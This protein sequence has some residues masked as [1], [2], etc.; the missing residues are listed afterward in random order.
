[1]IKDIPKNKQ[2]I[3]FDGVC[4]LCN[5]SV[6]YVIKR[7]KK[8]IFLFAPLQSKTGIELINK[9]NIDTTK[10]DSILLYNPKSNSLKQKSS[11]AIHIAKYLGFPSNLLTVFFIIP[12]FIRNWVYDYV[13][14][15][16]YKWY[17]KKDAC[18]IPTPEL[19]SKFIT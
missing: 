7:D 19:Q 6:L 8:D 2:V 16:R 3:L 1:M 14:K 13:A 10:T 18:M 17:G 11:A 4:N 15:N 12:T 5:S 9:F